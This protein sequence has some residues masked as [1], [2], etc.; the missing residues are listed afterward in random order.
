MFLTIDRISRVVFWL[1]VSSVISTAAAIIGL[2]CCTV[3]FTTWCLS[4]GAYLVLASLRVA[5]EGKA[6]LVSGC[7]SGFGHAVAL[8]LHKQ[9]FR[10]FAGCLQANAGGEGAKKLKDID[11]ERLHVLQLDVTKQDDIDQ[12]LKFVSDTLKDNEV[13]WGVINNA[14]IAIYGAVEWVSMATFKRVCE[15]N[16]FGTVALTK[17]CLPFIRKAKGRVVNVASARGR[18]TS[19]LGTTYEA[20]KYAIEGFSDG[21]RKEMK[22][23]GVDVCIIEPGNYVA[24]TS[25]YTEKVVDANAESLWLDMDDQVKEDYGGR[26]GFDRVLASQKRICSTGFK[27]ITPVVTAMDDSL[28]QK[29]PQ[30]RYQP[31]GLYLYLITF[32]SQHFP[33]WVSDYISLEI[34]MKQGW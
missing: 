19:P 17:A 15:V 4:A 31:M 10:V 20:T 1:C 32:I 13:L 25:V 27:D 22:S 16:L 30:E 24:G 3:F 12:A 26:D 9:G 18:M 34:L 11:P 8:H 23:W 29:Y 14:G 21:L 6:V 5:P 28:T 7:D 33:E 2:D